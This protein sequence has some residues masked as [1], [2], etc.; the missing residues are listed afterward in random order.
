VA[1]DGTFTTVLQLCCSVFVILAP[2]TKLQTYL[3]TYLENVTI[4][5]HFNFR[6]PDVAPVILRFNNEAPTKFEVRQ[7]IR[8]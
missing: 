2:D 1:N 6:L 7:P 3:L 8:S 5:M 4:A